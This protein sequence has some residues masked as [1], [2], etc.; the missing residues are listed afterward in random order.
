MSH[1]DCFEKTELRSRA[2]EAIEASEGGNEGKESKEDNGG[3]AAGGFSAEYLE[4]AAMAKEPRFDV[5]TTRCSDSNLPIFFAVGARA[6]KKVPP[7]EDCLA[8]VLSLPGVDVNLLAGSG[9]HRQTALFY[10]AFFGAW[11]CVK[12]LINH[13]SIDVN[14]SRSIGQTSLYIA[15]N[16]GH[17]KCVKLLLQVPGIKINKAGDVDYAQQ[18]SD[19]RERS[20]AEINNPLLETRFAAIR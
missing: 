19:I 8:L 18:A 5:N 6:D 7:R 15:A 9:R 12:L 1:A 2:V 3:D 13:Q 11:R 4:V 14:W 16:Q 10:A 20:V 17:T